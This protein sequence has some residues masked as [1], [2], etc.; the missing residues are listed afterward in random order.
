MDSCERNLIKQVTF[1]NFRLP[2]IPPKT[3]F[4]LVV[5]LLSIE[6]WEYGKLSVEEKLDEAYVLFFHV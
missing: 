5:E 4:M 6:N 3:N 2:E 1:Y